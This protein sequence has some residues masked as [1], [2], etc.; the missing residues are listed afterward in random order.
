MNDWLLPMGTTTAP[1]GVM[2]P[3]VPAE[4]VIVLARNTKL[5]V[6]FLFAFIVTVSG[7]VRPEASPLQPVNPQPAVG[8]AVNC[9]VEPSP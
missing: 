5:A 9:T 4:A 3:P 7:F 1:L 6:M 8:V 2:V